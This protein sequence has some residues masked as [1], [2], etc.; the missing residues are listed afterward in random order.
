MEK[1]E[2]RI[3]P[4][5]VLY[6]CV[7]ITTSYVINYL[8][9]SGLKQLAFT[10]LVSMGQESG[11]SLVESYTQGLSRLQ[12]GVDLG[13]GLPWG[14][15]KEFI[16]LWLYWQRREQRGGDPCFSLAIGW[17]PPLS[18]EATSSSHNGC[19]LFQGFQENLGHCSWLK[20]ISHNI[21]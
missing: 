4:V 20:Q 5:L 19:L 7:I 3:I 17:K 15:L 16:F 8:K 21:M 2:V 14:L 11:H 6:C 10:M 18:L 9:L 12:S 1:R 13:C